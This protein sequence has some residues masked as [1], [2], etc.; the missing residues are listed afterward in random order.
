M[1]VFL[2]ATCAILY[3]VITSAQDVWE[4]N[5]AILQFCKV[6]ARIQIVLKTHLVL[7]QIN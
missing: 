5:N 6:F 1:K 7:H 3:P 4:C 2:L